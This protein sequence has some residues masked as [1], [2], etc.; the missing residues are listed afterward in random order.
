MCLH[1]GVIFR[2]QLNNRCLF[3]TSAVRSPGFISL[4]SKQK[5]LNIRD[6]AHEKVVELIEK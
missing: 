3:Q 6:N 5:N 4:R 2:T 1:E